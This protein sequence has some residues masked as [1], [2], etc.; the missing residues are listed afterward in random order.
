MLL[1]TLAVLAVVVCATT[2]SAQP[3]KKKYHFSLA[4][5]NVK[6]E[7]KADVAKLA[8]PRVEEQVKKAFQTHPQVVADLGT[9]APDWKTKED[10]FRKHLAKHGVSGAFL[11]T[12]DVT[13]ASEELQPTDKPNTQRLV[14]KV[15]VHLLGEF[16]PGRTMGFTG[17]G[18]AT[19]KQEVGKK[20]SDRDRKFTWDDAAKAAV[21]DAMVT[22][23]K[24]LAA[25]V[26]PKSQKK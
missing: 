20:V 5:V 10:A 7:V 8:A 17:D 12:V 24:Q 19:I 2:A 4:A 6:P 11:V 15:S 9:A 3:N 18:S 22:V 14:V 21:D 16:M 23:F 25:G 26:A 1:R 13:D